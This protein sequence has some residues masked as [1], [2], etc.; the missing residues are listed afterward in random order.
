MP[1]DPKNTD[2][3]IKKLDDIGTYLKE[4]EKRLIAVEKKDSTPAPEPEKPTVDGRVT[5]AE[6]ILRDVLKDSYEKAKLDAW[7][8]NQLNMAWEMKKNFK[9]V[10]KEDGVP[11][12]PE[13]PRTGNI[14]NL[15]NVDPFKY[16][17]NVSSTKGMLEQLNAPAPTE[18]I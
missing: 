8:L 11:G 10:K 12:L 7:D 15:Q 13:A 4:F 18:G 2:I 16:A 5:V 9:P 6:T 17:V 14:Q 1:D 3:F